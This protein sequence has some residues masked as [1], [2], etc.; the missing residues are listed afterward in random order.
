MFSGRRWR[1][2]LVAGVVLILLPST[3]VAGPDRDP[4]R[5][6]GHDGV[7]YPSAPLVIEAPGGDLFFGMEY[8][9]ACALGAKPFERGLKALGRLARV[10]ERSGRR[11]VFTVAPAKADIVR[12]NLPASLLPQGSC[13]VAGL[14]AQRRLLNWFPD[15]NYV[16]ARKVVARTRG[17]PTGR[18]TCTG[19][20]S[21]CRTGPWPSPASSTLAWRGASAT[22]T[23]RRPRSAS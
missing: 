16:S 9:Y 10:I 13:D 14:N 15:D 7:E 23:S 22:A 3:A 1:R 2:A 11:A 5:I 17:R 6:L 20:R 19:A 8:D 12:E 4:G 21:V 18:P